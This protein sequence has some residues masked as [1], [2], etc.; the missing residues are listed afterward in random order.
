MLVEGRP[1]SGK[2][3]LANKIA[4][5][6]AEGKVSLTESSLSLFA[7]ITAD[8]KMFYHSQSEEFMLNVEQSH[9]DKTCFILHGHDD[10]SSQDNDSSIIYQL[11]H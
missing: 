5:D 2:T 9:G 10:F 1:G 7:R 4:K 3:T 8:Q 11:I 6:W